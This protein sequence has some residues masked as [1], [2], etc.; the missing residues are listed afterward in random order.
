M[1]LLPQVDGD[2]TCHAIYMLA[3]TAL[4]SFARYKHA[5]LLSSWTNT[6]HPGMQSMSAPEG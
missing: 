2:W 5:M 6:E 3:S 4:D 1:P